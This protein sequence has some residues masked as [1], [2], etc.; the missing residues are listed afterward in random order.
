[1]STLKM[2]AAAGTFRYTYKITRWHNA[3]D[4]NMNFSFLYEKIKIVY[5]ISASVDHVT[6]LRWKD[7]EISF[8]A[9]I[10]LSVM[11]EFLAFLCA[12]YK[13]GPSLSFWLSNPNRVRRLA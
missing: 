1:M 4:R 9:A 10:E 12:Y 6:E 8:T 13:F 2:E 3:D 11:N 7:S 5:I